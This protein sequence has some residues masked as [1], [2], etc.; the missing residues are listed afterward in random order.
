MSS[1]IGCYKSPQKPRYRDRRSRIEVLVSRATD[2]SCGGSCCYGTGECSISEIFNVAHR[3][4]PLYVA[5]VAS[6][7]RPQDTW[8]CINRAHVTLL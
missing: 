7:K 3:D 6:S 8:N 1:R 2:A 5:M 4:W